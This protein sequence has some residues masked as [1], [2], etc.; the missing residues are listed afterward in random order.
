MADALRST[1]VAALRTTMKYQSYWPW[2]ANFHCIGT[3]IL[4]KTTPHNL[5]DCEDVANF[6]FYNLELHFKEYHDQLSDRLLYWH[7][8]PVWVLASPMVS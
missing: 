7:Y 2:C 3:V 4:M 6:R 5:Y 1:S 8:N